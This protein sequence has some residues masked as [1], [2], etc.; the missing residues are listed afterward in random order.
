MTRLPPQIKVIDSN[1]FTKKFSATAVSAIANE[2]DKPAAYDPQRQE[3]TGAYKPW[4]VVLVFLVPGIA[5]F[6]YGYDCG[7]DQHHRR[8]MDIFCSALLFLQQLWE[9]L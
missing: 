4:S 9:L 8:R 6:L 7:A 2:D 1:N 5:D 3:D